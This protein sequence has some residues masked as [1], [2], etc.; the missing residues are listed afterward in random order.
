MDKVISGVFRVEKKWDLIWFINE[1]LQTKEIVKR[2]LLLKYLFST[3]DFDYVQK[4]IEAIDE[5][6]K[7][8]IDFDTTRVKLIVDKEQPFTK[9]MQQ[10]FNTNYILNNIDEISTEDYNISSNIKEL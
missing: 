3:F 8:I 10:F 4:I 5:N 2:D 9:Y 7:L 1:N 6:K